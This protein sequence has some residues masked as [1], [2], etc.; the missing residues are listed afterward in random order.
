M[1]QWELSCNVLCG[2]NGF[3]MA[4]GSAFYNIHFCVSVLL[5]NW[6]VLYCTESAGFSS[7]PDFHVDME[8]FE[9]CSL[10]MFI[11]VRS[12]TMI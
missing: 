5:E 8:A 12:S 7:G 9:S 1:L 10:S 11:G 6:C 2:V 4:S 3:G